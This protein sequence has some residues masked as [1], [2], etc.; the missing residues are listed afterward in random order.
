MVGSVLVYVVNWILPVPDFIVKRMT[1]ESVIVM[2][3]ANVSDAL[4]TGAEDEREIESDV[5]IK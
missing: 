3:V 5:A 4:E 1:V 2:G